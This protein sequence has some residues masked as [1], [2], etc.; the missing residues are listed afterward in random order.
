M[1]TMEQVLAELK[2]EDVE[3]RHWIEE[4][5]VLPTAGPE[6]GYLFDMADLARCRL[7][8]EL[9]RDLL[10]DEETM[11]LV[12]SLLDQVYALRSAIED[13][14]EAIRGLPEEART[15]IAARLAWPR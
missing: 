10:I 9:R 12:L 2:I 6:G 5:W 8:E 14:Q 7:I 13:L 4:R 1:W 15:E 11:P 3:L